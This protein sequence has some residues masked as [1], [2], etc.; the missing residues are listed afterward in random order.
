MEK[1]VRL[2]NHCTGYSY[3][4]DEHTLTDEEVIVLCKELGLKREWDLYWKI[5]EEWYV[6]DSY[7]CESCWTSFSYALDISPIE[8]VEQ[9]EENA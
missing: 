8:V 3:S 6:I 4:I 2:N 1:V 5:E 7:S 9:K